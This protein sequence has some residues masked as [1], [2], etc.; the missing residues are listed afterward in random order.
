MGDLLQAPPVLMVRALGKTY[1]AGLE[2]CW[3]NA[4]ALDDVHLEVLR[5]EVVAVVGGPGAGKTTLLRCAARLLT[6]DEGLVDR[7]RSERGDE[8]VVRYF[9]DPIHAGRAGTDE[10]PWDLALIDNVDRVHGDLAA[11]FALVRVV[12]R[13][14]REGASLLLTSRDACVVRE[15]ADRTLVLERGRIERRDVIDRPAIARVAEHVSPLTLIPGAPSI[16]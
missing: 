12:A 2:G 11:A 9:E 16:R 4:R 1:R 10:L 5:G 8:R 7:G 6:P 13:A 15:L 14:R 3:A